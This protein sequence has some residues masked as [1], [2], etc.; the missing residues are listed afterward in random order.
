MVAERN[1]LIL[2][3]LP[4]TPAEDVCTSTLLAQH[5]DLRCAVRQGD[6]ATDDSA[7]AQSPKRIAY[8][9]IPKTSHWK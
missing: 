6:L 8:R 5:P 7:S 4:E 1:T 3:G 9:F 2:Y